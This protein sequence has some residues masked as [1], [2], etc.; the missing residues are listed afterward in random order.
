[1]DK[2]RY[3][4]LIFTGYLDMT[5]MSK[6]VALSTTHALGL[7]IAKCKTHGGVPQRSSVSCM[8]MTNDNDKVFYS[9]FIIHFIFNTAIDVFAY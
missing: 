1:M 8:T 2:Y 4:G 5:I 9:T 6:A 3:L 7:T